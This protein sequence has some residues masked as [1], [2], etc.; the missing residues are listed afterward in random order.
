MKKWPLHVKILIGMLLGILWG[1]IAVKM[2]WSGFTIDY[3]KP[4]GIIFMNLLKLIA[5]PMIITSLI[6]GVSSL[7]DIKRLGRIGG[8]TI[9]IF[10]G[11]TVIAVTIGVIM[12]N[13]I[14]PGNAMPSET[15]EMLL[16][17]NSET[18]QKGFEDA[19]SVKNRGPLQPLVDLFPDNLIAAASKN[20]NMLQLVIISLVLGIGLI[21]ID[22]EK[23]K[24]VIAFMDG[25]NELVM[26]VVDL[27]MLIA[28]IGVFSL[29]AAMIV[30]LTKDD[31]SQTLGLF[32]ALGAYINTLLLALVLHV[33]LVYLP[34]VKWVAKL[35]PI[36]FLKKMRPV[37]LLA[38]ST[39]SSNAT[40]PVN[41]ENCEKELGVSEEIT[42]FVLPIG[43]T[44]NMDG[45]SCYQAV[46]TVF[47]AQVFQMDLSIMQQL[48]I[49]LTATLSS[50][51]TAGVPG[52][53]IVM[54]VIVLNSVGVP[55]EGIALI[56]GVDRIL[57]MCR[58]V[59]N[60]TGDAVVC[61]AI[62]K[63][64]GKLL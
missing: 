19:E 12:V 4:F 30:D 10:V 59:V 28:P 6:T 22:K 29:L 62:A 45:T 47:I 43:A 39:S 60:V 24:P 48:T 44:L 33:L 11:T 63:L 35:N 26:K 55:A 25:V 5:I 61:C 23:A 2:K 1:I 49:I 54:L 16:L 8:R 14:K 37:Q 38:F 32:M 27:I 17:S 41:M 40:L 53:G 21:L 20:T 36:W 51:G 31:L 58:T 50:I 13:L 3:V 46:A 34:L 9:G 56:M 64:E 18:V 57:D 42:G 7:N 15:K 52:V